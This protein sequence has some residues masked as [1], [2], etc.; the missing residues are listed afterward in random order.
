M[1][2][3]GGP[4]HPRR[5]RRAARRGTPWTD[6]EW[7]AQAAFAAAHLAAGLW[8]V[9]LAKALLLG[10]AGG[11]VLLAARAAALAAPARA[12]A[13]ALF[14]VG[15]LPRAD[16][17]TELFSIALFAGLLAGL[18][19][20][21][22]ADWPAR[23]I[24]WAVLSA[25]AVFGAWAN[26]HAGFPVG[27]ALLAAYLLPQVRRE[28]R[29]LAVLLA[30]VAA[31]FLN[32]YGPGLWAVLWEHARASD[33][34]RGLIL[35]WGPLGL[36]KASHLGAWSVVAAAF[37]ATLLCAARGRLP[38]LPE[39]F[40]L[41]L[42]A[43]T[44]RHARLAGYAAAAAPLLAVAAARAVHGLWEQSLPRRGAAAF[45][46]AA[47][48]LALSA[49]RPWGLAGGP[50]DPALVPT[51]TASWLALRP[52]LKG[53]RPYNPWSWGGYL[54]RRLGVRVY[55]DGRYLFHGLLAE[56]KQ[57]AASP[58]S[59]QA[60]LERTGA[61]VVLLENLPRMLPSTFTDKAGLESR[62]ERPYYQSYM[63]RERWALVWFD[64][65]ALVFVRRDRLP[66]G[67][68]EYRWLRPRDGAALG[69]ARAAGLVDEAALAAEAARKAAERASFKDEL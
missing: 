49:A 21:R 23:S 40:A 4:G 61:E 55:Q 58:E 18:E 63:P 17:R 45:C 66:E 44:A 6:F 29:W 47:L 39:L 20:L 59:W 7:A 36:A 25:A 64:A 38:A 14:G 1:A 12:L 31:T 9:W 33:A 67:L 26:L 28:R 22:A 42:A 52:E 43:S 8:G 27:L 41:A 46:A 3:V 30:A 57:A 35:E 24:G 53:L 69:L 2:P 11:A 37:G 34:L 10:A 5:G 54:S 68:A 13:L 56:Q 51:E 65:A 19:R 15:V 60:F 16:A 48:A 32:P 62:V 50:Y